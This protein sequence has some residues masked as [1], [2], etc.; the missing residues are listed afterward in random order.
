MSHQYPALLQIIIANSALHMSNAAHK[1]PVSN[2]SGI[3]NSPYLLDPKIGNFEKSQSYTD[4]MTAKQRA[5]GFLRCLIDSDAIDVDVTLAVIFLFVKFDLLH[6]G[7]GSWRCHIKGAEAILA[8]L[9]KPYIPPATSTSTLRKF[10]VSHYMVY[11]SPARFG[12][13]QSNY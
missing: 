6:S 11:V 1:C 7:R 10:L 9:R 13:Q 12:S 3:G 4:A 2:A 5:F 8:T